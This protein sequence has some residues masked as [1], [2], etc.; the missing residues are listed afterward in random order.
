MQMP[1]RCSS[2]ANSVGTTLIFGGS[3][4]QQKHIF[5]FRGYSID[6]F[7]PTV[8]DTADFLE[9]FELAVLS[10]SQGSVPI[11]RKTFFLAQSKSFQSAT[12]A[13]R[14]QKGLQKR[15]WISGLVLIKGGAVLKSVMSRKP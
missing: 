13:A 14:V 7:V 1:F 5:L 6:L 10:D 3:P 8:G 11:A 2:R 4:L 9:N 12:C 15:S